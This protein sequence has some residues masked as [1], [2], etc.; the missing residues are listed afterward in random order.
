MALRMPPVL[1][2]PRSACGNVLTSLEYWSQAWLCPVFSG[3]ENQRGVRT[4]GLLPRNTASTCGGP[5]SC[6]CLPTTAMAGLAQDP[7]GALGWHLPLL[8]PT[9]SWQLSLNLSPHRAKGHEAGAASSNPP[10]L[11][12]IWTWAGAGAWRPVEQGSC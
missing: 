2:K 9:L 5:E 4:F 1:T 11:A 12:P 3:A 10:Q 7:P 8:L 6:L